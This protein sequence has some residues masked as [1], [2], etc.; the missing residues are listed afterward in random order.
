M[1][2]IETLEIQK[3]GTQRRVLD[4]KP[5]GDYRTKRIPQ[6]PTHSRKLSEEEWVQA[7]RSRISNENCVHLS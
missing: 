2:I 4:R 3:S 5:E 1:G 6:M 7:S